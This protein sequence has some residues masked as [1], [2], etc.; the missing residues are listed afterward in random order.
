MMSNCALAMKNQYHD[1]TNDL[2]WVQDDS[3]LVQPESN[4]FNLMVLAS[5]EGQLGL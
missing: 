1:S 3:W 5:V 4:S 2:P